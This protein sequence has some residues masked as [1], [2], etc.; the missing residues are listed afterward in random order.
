MLQRVKVLDWHQF[1]EVKYPDSVTLQIVPDRTVRNNQLDILTKSLWEVFTPLHSRFIRQGFKIT[2]SKQADIWWEVYFTA[3]QVAF[4]L[5]VPK[6]HLSI[7]RQR[8]NAVWPRATA[9]QTCFVPNFELALTDIT[10][11]Q[12]KHHNFLSLDPDRRE[13]APLPTL[14][15]VVKDLVDG[16]KAILQLGLTPIERL[17]WQATAAEALQ[18]WQRGAIPKRWTLGAGALIADGLEKALDLINELKDALLDNMPGS[19]MESDNKADKRLLASLDKGKKELS[20]PTLQKAILPAFT[21]SIRVAAESVDSTRRKIAVHAIASSLK[22]LAGDNELEPVSVHFK[23]HNLK[24]VNGRQM[25]LIRFGKTVLSTAEVGS[26]MRLPTG[27]LQEQF[28]EVCQV[29]RREIAL[30][31][32]VTTSGI[33]IGDTKYKGQTVKTYYP[34][35]NRDEACLPLAIIGGMGSGKSLGAGAGF[36]ADV[37]RAGD[38][39]F[40]VDTANGAL[41]DAARDSLPKEFPEDHIID[42]DFGNSDWP[43]ALAWNEVATYGGRHAQRMVGKQLVNFLERFADNPGDQTRSITMMAAQAAFT[44]PTAT[45]L[46]VGM[47]LS[48]S[49]YREKLLKKIQNPRL[50]QNLADYHAMSEGARGQAT[51]PVWSRL[52]RLLDDENLA[53]CLCQK[54]AVDKD[55]KPLLDFRKFADAKDGPY[56]VCLRVPKSKLLPE[57]TNALVTYLVSKLWLAIL[58][59]YDGNWS[60][61]AWV[62]MDEP[63]QYLGAATEWSDMIVESRKWGLGMVFLFHSFVQLPKDFARVM[64]AAGPHIILYA[65]STAGDEFKELEKELAPFGL[66]EFLALPK[67]HALVSIYSGG[68]VPV[69]AAKMA[70]PPIEWNENPELRGPGRYSYSDRRYMIQRCSQRFGAHIGSVEQELWE[71]EREARKNAK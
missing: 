37:I 58:T 6:A 29:S 8:L 40:L 49:E 39:V 16:D 28:P 62:I 10:Q 48:S 57:A 41:C 30:P 63:H 19:E 45:L 69:F 34:L 1:F 59:R 54:I 46:E 33:L 52:N 65:S 31:T 12:L 70:E 2:Y 68:R 64:K 22:E 51:R 23:K 38:T 66:E 43:I 27:P 11:V 13:N 32:S 17:S 7:I 67:H 44:D 25:P 61:P 20:A 21:T 18:K 35:K 55:G 47:V 9:L 42:L 4:Y 26:L 36:A 53:N 71:R 24:Q 14:L 15:N 60:K 5:T 50:H 3:G 56:L